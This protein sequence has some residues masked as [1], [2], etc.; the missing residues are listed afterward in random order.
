MKETMDVI[1]V[2]EFLKFTA[3]ELKK[4]LT[5]KI[6]VMFEDNITV[7]LTAAEIVVS[8]YFWQLFKVY[9]T[10]PLTSK[11]KIS[12]FFTNNMF[13]GKTHIDFTS[14]L[15]EDLVTTV[16]SKSNDKLHEE[17]DKFFYTLYDFLETLYSGLSY[18]IVEY[19]SSINIVDL[20]DI[21]LDEDLM[22]DMN[23]VGEELGIGAINKAYDTLDHVIRNNVRFKNNPVAKAYI[24][25]MV[26]KNQM[27]Q[28]LGPRGYVT[29]LDSAIFKYP[30]AS[31]FTLG[32]RNM[33]EMAT[34]SRSG[35][36]ALFLSSIGIQDSEYFGRELHLATMPIERLEFTDCGS[37]KYLDWYVKPKE[38]VG[39]QVLYNGDLKHLVG[40]W[41][42]NEETGEEEV[43][44]NNHTHLY[45]KH[46]KMRSAINCTLD[47]K[48]AIC[49]KCFGELAYGIPKHAN[50]GHICSTKINSK[51]SQSILST[52]HLATSASAGAIT[53]GDIA[54]KFFMIKDKNGYSF[55]SN[56]INAKVKI[57]IIVKQEECFGLKDI[58]ADKS[59]NIVDP[60][61]VSR[62]EN[63]TIRYESKTKT[64]HFVIPVKAGNRYGVFE[65]KFLNYIIENG[66]ETDEYDNYIISVDNWKFVT[67]ILRL[68]EVEF[69]FLA[70]SRDTK[71]MFKKIIVL[72][73]G[74]SKDTPESLLS[75]V[76]TLV[77]SKLDINI[78]LFEVV[79]YAFTVYDL[80]NGNYDLGRNSPNVQLANLLTVIDRRSAG[81]AYGYDDL[82]GKILMPSM[83]TTENKCDHKLDVLLAANQI[84]Q[85]KRV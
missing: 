10:V 22:R 5:G 26:N 8:R 66:Y 54:R 29:E 15:M 50:L 42:L 36:K 53:L 30:I 40:K 59:I 4:D 27:K 68:P 38:V 39:E 46:I 73:G 33:Y 24:S 43:I 81:A 48:R 21:Q 62:I 1:P 18:L 74:I 78:A 25:G 58:K 85:D 16:F 80:P 61:R 56:V 57:S 47:D 12:E 9:K 11:Y 2:K 84:L 37:K 45:G 3:E 6:N 20:L 79:V 19:V 77:N 7:E 63:I 44:T 72:K 23:R 51:I 31:S 55:R 75:K 49:S 14:L 71:D 52:K 67:P 60:G 82:A 35:A 64:E 65:L 41:Y 28:V 13:T 83:F 17:L 76:F 32:L 34:D 69:S 70:L